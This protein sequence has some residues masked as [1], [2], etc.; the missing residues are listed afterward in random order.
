MSEETKTVETVK[1]KPTGVM[2]GAPRETQE[3]IN[4][5][6]KRIA[7]LEAELELLK[8]GPVIVPL[9]EHEEKTGLHDSNAPFPSPKIVE[10]TPSH[11]GYYPP[12]TVKKDA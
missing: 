2:E 9:K 10:G 7:A 5:R 12:K 8:K 6:E 4:A 11:D 3:T 1:A